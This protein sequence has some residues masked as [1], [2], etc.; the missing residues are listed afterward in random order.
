MEQL[1]QYAIKEYEET[2][3]MLRHYDNVNLRFSSVLQTGVFIFIGLSFG[4]LSRDK[5][6]F[7]VFFPVVIIFTSVSNFIMFAWF[8]RHRKI[9]QLKIKRIL[10]LE[11]KLNYQQFKMVDEAIKLKKLGRFPIRYLVIIY[12]AA[13]P[14]SLIVSYV[15]FLT[16]N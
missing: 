11:V 5:E 13:I 1:D 9:S 14:G 16:M 8:G 2:Q 4:L 12:M 7:T 3:K 10:E 15:V 6:M